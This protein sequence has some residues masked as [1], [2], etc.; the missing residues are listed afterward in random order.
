MWVEIETLYKDHNYHNFV[1]MHF[2]Y[3]QCLICKQYANEV[4]HVEKVARVGGRKYDRYDLE[5]MPLC[6]KHHSEVESIGEKTF[7]KKY[8]LEGGIV[9]TENEYETIKDKYKGHFKQAEKNRK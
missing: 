9:L 3:C 5:R 1:F 8:A 7:N 6:T 2:K 4:H